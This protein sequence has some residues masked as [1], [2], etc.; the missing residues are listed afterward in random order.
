MRVLSEGS[1]ENSILVGKGSIIICKLN[2]CLRTKNSGF[3]D[4]RSISLERAPFFQKY[5]EFFVFAKEFRIW[6]FSFQLLFPE[7]EIKLFGQYFRGSQGTWLI[8]TKS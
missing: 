2:F 6:S 3:E 8:G 1:L 7:V 5:V 4:C